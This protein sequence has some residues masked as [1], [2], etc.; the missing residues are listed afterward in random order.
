MRPPRSGRSGE[1]SEYPVSFTAAID[2][3]GGIVLSGELD[4]GALPALKTVLDQAL[5]ESEDIV[6]EMA[7]LTFI[8]SRALTELLRF[9]LLVVAQGR[10]LLL[11]R[12]SRPVARLIERLDLRHF[13]SYSVDE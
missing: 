5:A 12:P 8:G 4:V 10:Q 13:F 11:M 9:Q 1:G 6:I 3:G 7:G 2:S